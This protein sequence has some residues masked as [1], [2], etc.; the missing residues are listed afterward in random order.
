[1]CGYTGNP[2]ARMCWS[3]APDHRPAPGTR[4]SAPDKRCARPTPTG[5][6]GTRWSEYESLRKQEEDGEPQPQA[7]P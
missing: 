4:T 6:L 5:A 2:H 1:M 7:R 3:G